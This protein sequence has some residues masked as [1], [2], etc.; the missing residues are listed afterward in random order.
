MSEN[1]RKL[2]CFLEIEAFYISSLLLL[3]SI[4]SLPFY[5]YF[6]VVLECSMKKIFYFSLFSCVLWS[7]SFFYTNALD[8]CQYDDKNYNQNCLQE[9]NYFSQFV[10]LASPRQETPIERSKGNQ[11]QT[12]D[13]KLSDTLRDVLPKIYTP[14]K[15]KEKTL[16]T[17]SS[18]FL[19]CS[20][21]GKTESIKRVCKYFSSYIIGKEVKQSKITLDDITSLIR[22]HSIGIPRT[23][24]WSDFD[25]NFMPLDYGRG[26]ITIAE[27]SE[28]WVGKFLFWLGFAYHGHDN[29]VE[30]LWEGVLVLKAGDTH[31]Q[32]FARLYFA[33]KRNYSTN[34]RLTLLNHKL[35][36]FIPTVTEK[37]NHYFT[38]QYELQKNGSWK[39]KACFEEENFCPKNEEC[40]LQQKKL[41]LMQCENL[42]IMLTT[43]LSK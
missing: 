8:A 2:R 43:T 13:E 18:L 12:A 30:E 35:N 31:W 36:Y 9:L 3:F 19:N 20:E 22:K 28:L 32:E 10:E 1:C 26:G 29:L 16:K 5:W 21:S 25:E 39:L 24:E 27:N 15:T 38:P 17:L 40:R 42:W 34:K 4:E 33:D 7:F 41:L 37:E 11:A 23:I 14:L 6:I